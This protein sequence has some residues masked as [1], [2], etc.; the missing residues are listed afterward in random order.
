M[1]TGTLLIFSYLHINTTLTLTAQ[2]WSDSTDE[3]DST[4]G[5]INVS[6]YVRIWL[7]STPAH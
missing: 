4:T 7:Q 2:T 3:G 6:G 5:D 1:E